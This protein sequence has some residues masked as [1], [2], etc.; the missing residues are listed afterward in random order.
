MRLIKIKIEKFREKNLGPVLVI[1]VR[2]SV[3]GLKIP[4]RVPGLAIYRSGVEVNKTI[5]AIL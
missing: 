1:Y 3:Y 2:A 5:T 4:L